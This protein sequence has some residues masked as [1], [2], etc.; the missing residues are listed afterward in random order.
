MYVPVLEIKKGLVC[1]QDQKPEGR[2]RGGE[3]VVFGN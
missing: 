2:G 3:I 1:T